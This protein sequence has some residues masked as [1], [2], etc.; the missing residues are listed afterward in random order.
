M[1]KFGNV[2]GLVEKSPSEMML[3][4]FVGLKCNN[5]THLCQSTARVEYSSFRLDIEKEEIEVLKTCQKLGIAIICYSPLGRGMLIGQLK[6]GDDFKENDLRKHFLR[7]SK[8][9]FMEN[10]QSILCIKKAK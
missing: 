7:F 10:L 5:S 1:T 2:F 3:L 8:E 9:K 4:I 6:S